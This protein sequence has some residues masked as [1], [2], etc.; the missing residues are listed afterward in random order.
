MAS[1]RSGQSIFVE[2]ETWELYGLRP[3]T[4]CRLQLAKPVQQDVDGLA[5]R[6]LAV[7]AQ[8]DEA[9]GIAGESAFSEIVPR[10]EQLRL[11]GLERGFKGDGDG[12]YPV[13]DSVVELAAVARP[14]WAHAA[15]GRD[16]KLSRR[17][18]KRCDVDL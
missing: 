18:R 17:I 1:P 10:E 3:S 16:L 8:H 15:A 14:L 6:F 11:A 7:V 9:R 12:H 4:E 2:A 13:V 5:R